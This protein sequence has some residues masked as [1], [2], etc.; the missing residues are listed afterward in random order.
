MRTEGAKAEF[1]A[2]ALAGITEV[3]E[4][5]IKPRAVELSPVTP[6]GLQRNLEMGKK[7]VKAT[8]TGHNRQSVDAEV[9]ETE[10]GIKATLFT[11]SGYGGYLELG[12]A[13][14]AAQPYLMPAF[15]EF[16]PTIAG[17]IKEKL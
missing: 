13:R 14:M 2:A 1:K 10:K 3:F 6:E 11:A 7:G 12:T 4:L 17:K 5:D 9:E 15:E 8:G 16:S